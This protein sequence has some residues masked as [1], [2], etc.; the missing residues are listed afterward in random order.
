MERE[1]T[2][3]DGQEVLERELVGVALTAL[4]AAVAALSAGRAARA[5]TSADRPGGSLQVLILLGTWHGFQ[6]PDVAIVPQQ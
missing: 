2:R 5:R 4:I 3:N 1:T 6:G